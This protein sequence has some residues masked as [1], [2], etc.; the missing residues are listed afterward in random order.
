MRRPV[1]GGQM[2][3]LVSIIIPTYNR[4]LLLRRALQSVVDQ[5]YPHW[6]ALVVDNHSRDETD[7]VVAG[8]GDD[9]IH[10]LKIHN[11]GVIAA[12]RNM[13]LEQA[14]GEWAAF[15]DSDDA[16]YPKKLEVLM[17]ALDANGDYEVL[18]NDELIVFTETGSR[19][20]LRYGPFK[21]NFYRTLLVGGNRLSPSATLVQR[22]FLARHQLA[23]AEGTDYVTVED[24]GLWLDLARRGARFKFLRNVEGEFVIHGENSSGQHQQHAENNEA[25]LRDHVFNIQQFE[26]RPNRLWKLVSARLRFAKV[27]QLVKDRKVVSALKLAVGTS[28]TSP[29]GTAMHLWSVLKRRFREMRTW[30][31][32]KTG[33]ID[34]P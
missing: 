32:L 27:R 11:H 22:E 18:S 19:K 15:L 30:L 12:S 31:M 9:R 23:F 17:G 24:Y 26:P 29:R 5:T 33:R 4:A 7:D 20:I 16:W 34:L 21:Q 3:P 10:L 2:T 6:E 13:G 8:F 1:T 28:I 25:L 14:K